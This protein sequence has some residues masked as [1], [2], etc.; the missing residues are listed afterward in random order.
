[1]QN[2]KSEYGTIKIYESWIKTASYCIKKTYQS[3]GQGRIPKSLI[4][5]S[6]RVFPGG[7]EFSIRISASQA[8]SITG[9][10]KYRGIEL[11]EQL[12]SE[13]LA[14]FYRNSSKGQSQQLEEGCNQLS[15]PLCADITKGESEHGN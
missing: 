9:L 3:N 10:T 13:Q 2:N 4:L 7:S 5:L 11:C 6:K 14:V 12:I 15:N 8:A 1:M